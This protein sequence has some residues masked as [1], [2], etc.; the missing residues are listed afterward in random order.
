VT[1]ICYARTS[2][3]R[4]RVGT[5]LALTAASGGLLAAALAVAPT[6]RADD[7]SDI[8]ANIQ[9]SIADGKADYTAAQADY[10]LGTPAGDAAGA[11][12]D[13]SGTNDVLL[14]PTID[15]ITGS[16]Q[17]LAGETP[18]GYAYFT[19]ALD[20]TTFSAL[21][22]DVSNDFATGTTYFTDAEK[23]FALGTP[24]GDADGVIYSLAG[25]DWDTINAPQQ[26]LLGLADLAAAGL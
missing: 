3:Q 14:G 23:Y 15:I 12:L 25:F 21:E 8:V 7:F 6:A 22:T 4:R 9:S 17:A 26:A 1:H 11:A 24:A 19:P 20:P 10:A 18:T 16:T 5:T 2:R 13:T